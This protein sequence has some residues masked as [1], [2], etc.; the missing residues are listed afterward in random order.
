MTHG[1]VIPLASLGAHKSRIRPH[2]TRYPEVQLE[3]R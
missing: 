3:K 1:A 2:P